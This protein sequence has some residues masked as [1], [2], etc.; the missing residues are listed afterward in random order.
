MFN[1]FRTS[2]PVRT[3]HDL[4]NFACCGM[5]MPAAS[6]ANQNRW[7]LETCDA[8]DDLEC[9][10]QS[11]ELVYPR[12]APFVLNDS[13]FKQILPLIHESYK[14]LLHLPRA[15]SLQR[16]GLVKHEYH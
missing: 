5:P 10:V 3:F 6:Q 7:L 13:R 12:R 9:S 11:S 2:C 15:A 14:E 4:Q 1:H 8:K 16:G